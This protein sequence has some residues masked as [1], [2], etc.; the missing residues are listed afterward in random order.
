MSYVTR[1]TCRHCAGP[2]DPVFDLGPIVPSHFPRPEEPEWP[3]IPMTV[4]LCKDCGFVQLAQTIDDDLLYRLYWYVSGTNETMCAE[5]AS[6]V[7]AVM[8]GGDVQ[9]GDLVVDVG[10]ND[11]TLLS[12]YP[13]DVRR[14]AFEPAHNLIERCGQHADAVYNEFFPGYA[15]SCLPPHSVNVISSI[16]MFYD[17]EDPRSFVAEV[18]RL[19]TYGGVWVV[20]LQDLAQQVQTR[21]FDNCC[22]EHR[23]YYSLQSL[24]QILRGFDLHVTHAE[25]RAIN[26]GSLRMF[27]QRRYQPVDASVERLLTLEAPYILPTALEKFAWEAG[28]VRTQLQEMIHVAST[29]GPIDLYAACYD[30]ETRAVT[31][32]GFKRY[33]ELTTEDRVITLNPETQAVE[34]QQVRE[35]MMYPYNG[36]L[37][38]FTGKRVDL[39]VTPNHRMLRNA[40][41][42]I[43]KLKFEDAALLS[44][45]PNFYIP[46]GTSWQGKIDEVFSLR[47]WADQYTYDRRV[48]R[49]PMVFATDDFLYLLGLFIGDGYIP[50]LENQGYC[51]NFCVPEDDKARLP[52]E[53]TLSRMGLGYRAYQTEVQ[54]AGRALLDVFRTC[55]S[56]ATE[57]RIP[58]WALD[59][60]V[61]HLDHLFRGLIDSDGHYRGNGRV[62]Y[63]TSSPKLV[64]DMLEL[65]AKLGR[66][67]TTATLPPA[68][69]VIG[70]HTAM[71]QETYR[72]YIGT[73]QGKCYSSHRQNYKGTVWCLSVENGNFMVERNGKTAFCGNSTKS[74]TLLQ[75]CGLDHT[76]IRQAVERTPEKVGRVTGGTRIPIVSEETWRA[77][78]APTTLVGA[79]QFAA[80]FEQREAEYLARGG[81]F[82]IPL[83]VARVVSQR[84]REIA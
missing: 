73:T 8:A 60:A 21:A 5:L 32:D 17:L 39:L 49:V 24:Q 59:Y 63:S 37:I 30:E 23:G 36:E 78:P 25:R 7:T 79:Y 22:F 61:P 53:A 75:Y 14:L 72:L 42:P 58:R 62:G 16:A 13:P 4:T 18:D 34:I 28:Q 44:T 77:D 70:N 31:T 41:G 6:V 69:Y 19:L 54:V 71:A 64:T 74:S 20:Q 11:G 67:C 15:S 68:V 46:L 35:V 81:Q 83:P 80:A 51:T 82:L 38:H 2:L 76:V 66:Q 50:K 33:D 57:K 12:Y 84:T 65:C 26:G 43:G 9:R 48:K 45:R 52:L 1:T 47:Q 56:T 40:R 27:V 3:A 10:A 29:V 55:G